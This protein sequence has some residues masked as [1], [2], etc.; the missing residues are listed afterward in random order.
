MHL[1]RIATIW[2]PEKGP[3]VPKGFPDGGGFKYF[4]M[5][6]PIWGNDPVWRASF[7]NGLKP[8]T[9]YYIFFNTHLRNTWT[10]FLLH[11][12]REMVTLN[13][14][15]VQTPNFCRLAT[16]FA[17]IFFIG[18]M[19][20]PL[21]WRAPSSLTPPRSRLTEDYDIPNTH[22]IRCIW[23]NGTFELVHTL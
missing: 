17:Q 22:Y 18:K 2:S 20:V 15:H 5:F 13:S 1:G 6:I 19:V 21:G 23:V 12:W 8:P 9:G 11:I 10:G 14:C 4:C 7:S 16:V 3:Q